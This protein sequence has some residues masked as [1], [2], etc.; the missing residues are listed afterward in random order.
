MS[1]QSPVKEEEMS[2]PVR[3]KKACRGLWQESMRQSLGK[4]AE[5]AQEGKVAVGLLGR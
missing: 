1:R 2:I 5:W 4:S 3:R